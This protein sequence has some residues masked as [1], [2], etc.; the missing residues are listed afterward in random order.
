MYPPGTIYKIFTNSLVLFTTRFLQTTDVKL[1]S[2]CQR[3]ARVKRHFEICK[4][5]WPS[6]TRLWRTRFEAP[7]LVCTTSVHRFQVHP[8]R[9]YITIPCER[10]ILPVLRVSS[11]QAS[12]S[13]QSQCCDDICHT[14]LIR[15]CSHSKTGCNP[16][17]E[18]LYLFPLIS[19]RAVSQASSQRWRWRLL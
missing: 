11:H 2:L 10:L 12:A 7:K 17:L 6:R 16:I 14:V 8:V 3:A 1:D 19:M 4:P 5:C 15:E 18:W 13:I 9:L